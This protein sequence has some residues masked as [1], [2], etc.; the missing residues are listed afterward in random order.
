MLR[1]HADGDVGTFLHREPGGVFRVRLEDVRY[2][3]ASPQA[4]GAWGVEARVTEAGELL[5][6]PVR[7]PR[8]APTNEAIAHLGR[9]LL[10]RLPDA[11]DGWERPQACRDAGPDAG[12]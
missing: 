3:W 8:E 7:F 4:R 5:S 2:S 1:W 10:G 11:E 6:A 12:P 9:L